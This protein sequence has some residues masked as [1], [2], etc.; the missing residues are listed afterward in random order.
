MNDHPNKEIRKAVDYAL[1]HGWQLEKG[2]GHS[3]LLCPFHQRN[4]CRLSVNCTPR[5][6]HNEARRIINIVDKCQ[7][8]VKK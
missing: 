6:P 2:A 4:G 3:H 1:Q 7:H 5:N 8:Y